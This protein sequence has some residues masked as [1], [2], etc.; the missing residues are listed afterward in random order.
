MNYLELL[1]VQDK[2]QP[3][4][5]FS[6]NLCQG[7]DNC[8]IDTARLH[9]QNPQ[10]ISEAIT[11]FLGSLLLREDYSSHRN[12]HIHD[13]IVVRSRKVGLVPID[14]SQDSEFPVQAFLDVHQVH[15][16]VNRESDSQSEGK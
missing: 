6:R 5:R 8:R 2:Q 14:D 10:M 4:P 9:V 15:K 16:P 3:L 12:F 7:E 11:R 1:I 13:D